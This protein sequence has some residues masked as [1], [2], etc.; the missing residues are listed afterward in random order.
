MIQLC[1]LLLQW[2]MRQ[3][4]AKRADAL[5]KTKGQFSATK[6]VIKVNEDEMAAQISKFN[7]ANNY[8]SRPDGRDRTEQRDSGTV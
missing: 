3:K 1:Q 2:N 6:V 4:I 5:L 7:F 8:R